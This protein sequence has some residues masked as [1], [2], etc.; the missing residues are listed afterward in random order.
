ML[1]FNDLRQLGFTMKK[2]LLHSYDLRHLDFN[3]FILAMTKNLIYPQ[4]LLCTVPAAWTSRGDRCRSA[5]V[6]FVGFVA[7]EQPV[8]PAGATLTRAAG[9]AT[10]SLA[11]SRT[12]PAAFDSCSCTS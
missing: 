11:P 10:S 1:C 2:Q 9:P 12:L 5:A 7:S 8:E 6:G 3:M 4:L